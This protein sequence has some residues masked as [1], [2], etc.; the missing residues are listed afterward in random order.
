[1]EG[2]IEQTVS[3]GPGAL[4]TMCAY[5]G[6]PYGISIDIVEDCCN[7]QIKELF[8]KF[9]IENYVET[10]PYM[11]FCKAPD[12]TYAFMVDEKF[13]SAKGNL[14][15][16]NASCH[17]GTPVCLRCK[18]VSHEPLSCEMYAAWEEN[19]A[20]IYDKLNYLWKMDNTKKCPG[21]KADIQKNAGCNFMRCAKC[22]QQFCWFCLKD[23]KQHDQKHVWKASC[24]VYEH[25]KSVEEMDE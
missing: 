12:C 8:E 24:N 22:G 23:W 3:E 25:K 5:Y 2:Y 18:G 13:L 6:C 14:A 15:Q 16:R 17:C 20:K 4:E 9:Y 7:K 19:I 1:M 10:A 21:C 11:S